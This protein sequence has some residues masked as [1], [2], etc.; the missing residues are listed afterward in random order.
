MGSHTLGRAHP[1]D[2]GFTEPWMFWWGS[3]DNTY[4]I[5]MLSKTWSQTGVQRLSQMEWTDGVAFIMLN[6]DL[7]LL[8]DIVPTENGTVACGADSSQCA[9]NPETAHIVREF[10]SDVQAWLDA[11]MHAW[12]V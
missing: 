4:Y 8:K 10:A 11:Y 12:K 7:A 3:L 9:D 5:E 6:T 2:S 1:A